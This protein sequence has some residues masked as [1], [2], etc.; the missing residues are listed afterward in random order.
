MPADPSRI[1][2][3]LPPVRVA[4][5]LSP[6]Y[7]YPMGETVWERGLSK[8]SSGT[9]AVPDGRTPGG[10][11]KGDGGLPAR[12]SPPAPR[13]SAGALPG[14][15][16]LRGGATSPAAFRILCVR[17]ACSAACLAR[18][19]HRGRPGKLAGARAAAGGRQEGFQTPPRTQADPLD[20]AKS[21]AWPH[22]PTNPRAAEGTTREPTMLKW[23]QPPKHEHGE[24]P[25]R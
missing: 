16:R 14:R 23:A 2:A 3:E 13:P 12:P 5:L 18:T 1:T 9:S 11:V 24:N 15:G 25:P 10:S 19:N 20:R 4:A 21:A 8:C 6:D 22:T 17:A 7:S